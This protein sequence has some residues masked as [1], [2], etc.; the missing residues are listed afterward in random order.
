MAAAILFTFPGS[1]MI[2]YGDEAGMEGAADP[3]NRR[4]YPWGHE[5]R[6]LLSWFRW[7][8]QLR[9]NRASLRRG[10]LRWLEA[11]GSL[12]AYSREIFGETTVT[13]VN[14]SAQEEFLPLPEEG[15]RDL[16]TGELLSGE[17]ALVSPYS[18]RLLGRG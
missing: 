17:T 6:E 15:F 4:T 13:L 14:G 8:G 7:L 11:R 12:L 2:Y 3:F 9:K 5:D 18:V 10:S 16:R 1:P